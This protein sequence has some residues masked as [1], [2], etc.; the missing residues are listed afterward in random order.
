[1][2]RA[3]RVSY[4]HHIKA[5]LDVPARARGEPL[6]TLRFTVDASLSLRT[7]AKEL[8]PSLSPSSGDLASVAD[9]GGELVG[10]TA[11]DRFAPPL[12]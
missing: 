5:P 9:W 10:T 3:V 11:S 6:P 2:P 12:R 1:M 4:Q 7:F 8:E